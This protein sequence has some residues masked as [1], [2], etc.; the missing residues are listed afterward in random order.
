MKETE[1]R[2]GN[3]VYDSTGVVTK[4]ESIIPEHNRIRKPIPLT[5]ERLLRFGYI[6]YNFNKDTIRYSHDD[7][8]FDVELFGSRFAFCVHDA[9]SAPHLT[10]YIGH[11]YYVHEFQNTFRVLSG[12]E[13]IA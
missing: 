9:E 8:L 1:L 5:E 13:L 4:V 12:V 7:C 11:G 10:N 2:I 3:L 6:K